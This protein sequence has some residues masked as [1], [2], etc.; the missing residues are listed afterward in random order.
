ML[1]ESFQSNQLEE[2]ELGKQTWSHSRQAVTTVNNNGAFWVCRLSGIGDNRNT[3]K[4]SDSQ[5]CVGLTTVV[6]LFYMVW[7]L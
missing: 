2:S 5:E 3:E 4:A 7:S 1:L 6:S